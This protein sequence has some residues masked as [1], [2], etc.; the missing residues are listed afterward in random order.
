MN[1]GM[2]RYKKKRLAVSVITVSVLIILIQLID[3]YCTEIFGRT[4]SLSARTFLMIPKEWTE[5]PP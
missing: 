4:Q 3:S 2:E 5:T 1:S